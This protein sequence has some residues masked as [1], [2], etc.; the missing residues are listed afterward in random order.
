MKRHVSIRPEAQRDIKEAA[1]WYESREHGVGMRFK[2]EVRNTLSRI[3]ENALMS[4]AIDSRVRR[5]LL[6][7]FPY[8]VYFTVKAKEVVILVRQT[9]IHLLRKSD[10]ASKNIFQGCLINQ[11]HHP[12]VTVHPK[13]TN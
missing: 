4:P 3:G 2:S 1:T 9:S 13:N 10:Q 11:D 7:D 5:A 12:S 8:S 6:R